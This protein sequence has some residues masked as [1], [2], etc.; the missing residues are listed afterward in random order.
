MKKLLV[1]DYDET[2]HI[3]REGLSEN[4]E[5]VKRFREAGNVF[6][7]ATGR[8]YTDFKW[9]ESEF[10]IE[11]DMLILDHGALILDGEGNIL[12][13]SSIDDDVVMAMKDDLRIEKCKRVFCTSGLEG[14]VEF[15][16][17]NI[18]KVNTWYDNEKDPV[19]VLEV[20][21][22]KYGNDVNAY[23]IPPESLEII[24]KTSAKEVAIDWVAKRLGIPE[25]N[26][27]TT[28][29]GYSDVAMVKK[30]NGYAVPHAV[31]P[32]KE[33]AKGVVNTVTELI[34]MIMKK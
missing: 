22:A 10:G 19:E 24:T 6:I 23:Y 34:D 32:L 31:E 15:D 2:F 30:Y 18:Q 3:T 5:S 33:A 25:E 28:G 26:I 27:Y 7:F 8:S 16:H 14:R 21:W 29:D 12:F 17:G 9:L 1:S 20:I 4:I 11:Y 13:S